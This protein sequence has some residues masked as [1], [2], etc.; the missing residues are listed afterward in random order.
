[1]PFAITI[2]VSAF[3]LFQVQPVIARFI[4]PWYGGSPAVWS[5][6]M[7]FFQVGL[8]IGYVYAHLLARYIKARNQVLL[9]GVLLILSLIFLPITPDDA[10]KPGGGGDPIWGIIRLLTLTVGAPYVLISST[11]PLLQHWY[12]RRYAGKSPYRLYALSNFGS[13]LGLLTYPF[14]VEPRM[15]LGSQTFFWSAGYLLFAAICILSGRTLLS[16]DN[17]AGSQ[18]DSKTEPMGRQ[19]RLD[20]LLWVGLAACGSIMLLAV[21]SK[22]TQD[23]SVIPFLW[24]LPLSLYL[25]TFIIAFDSPK[26]Y[27]REIWVPAFLLSAG[28]ITYLL[29]PKTDLPIVTTIGLYSAAMFCIVMVCHGELVR[30]K[31]PPRRLTFFYLMISLGGALGGAFVNFVATNV[32]AAFWE[33]H[34]SVSLAAVLVGFS[35]LRLRGKRAG[36]GYSAA[37]WSWAAATIVLV[38]FLVNTI[39]EAEGD[40]LTTLRNFYGVLRV[41]EQDKDKR[42][43]RRKLYHGQINHGLQLL[44]PKQ[45]HRIVS[46]YSAHSG[47]GI[48]FRRHPKRLAR[49]S[50]IVTDKQNLNLHVGVIGLGI[51]VVASWGLPGDSF[52][53][54]EINPGVVSLANE[55]F[56]IMKDSKAMLKVIE[57]DGRISL[58]REFREHG[59][60]QFDLLI[61]DAFAGDAIPVHLVTREALEL[62]LKHL[63]A[64][65]IL[66]LHISNRHL[67]LM[68]V[69]YGLATTLDIPAIL[70]KKKK[71]SRDYIKGSKWVLLT[72][73][74]RFLKHPRVLKYV[75]PW[76]DD[77]RDDIVWTDNYSS[78]FEL[79]K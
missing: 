37:R 66:A 16:A 58:E 75:T 32:F 26:W 6:C 76:P 74:K 18:P 23:F 54:Y 28:V 50:Q 52:R 43:H 13:L 10:L 11:G 64:D 22:I 27:R 29:Q 35:L 55:Y 78:I 19:N 36:R 12:N 57:G 60:M 14:L 30:S 3:L 77:I 7:M 4:L 63:R 59:S 67:D 1:M 39:I 42:S 53:F 25:C 45:K 69:V 70:V 21:T 46:Y 31:P 44:H 38:A 56:T 79:L 49:S 51:G 5:T 33:L 20:P 8:L 2:F 34:V 73:N 62:Y 68:P 24:V 47:L 72:K 65:G 17:S 61:A 71:R 40:A 41:H 9:H 48:A 15:A